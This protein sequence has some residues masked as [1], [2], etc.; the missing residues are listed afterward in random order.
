MTLW[1]DAQAIL[2]DLVELRR[3]LHREPEIGSQL[4]LTQAR[5]LAALTDLPLEITTGTALTSVTAVLRGGRPGPAV[6]LR[7]DMSLRLVAETGGGAT[8]LAYNPADSKLY[9]LTPTNGV[10][11]VDLTGSAALSATVFRAIQYRLR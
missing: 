6:L 9:Y 5:L 2:A 11:Q 4:P 10:Y 3:E 8:K 7:S 1:E